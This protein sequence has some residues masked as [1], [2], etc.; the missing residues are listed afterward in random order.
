V[1]SKMVRL[2]AGTH[3][4]LAQVRERL[5][6]AY[7]Q[8]QISLPDSQAEG[9]T[10]DFVIQRLLRHYQDHGRRRARSRRKR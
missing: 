7:Q 4:A 8:G 1:K 3:T 6:A 2:R 5:F 10:F 9:V